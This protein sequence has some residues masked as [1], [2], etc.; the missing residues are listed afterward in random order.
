M[1]ILAGALTAHARL[2]IWEIGG[3]SAKEIF[4]RDSPVLEAESRLDPRQKTDRDIS[5]L[6]ASRSFVF[7]SKAV[8]GTGSLVI[9]SRFETPSVD[10]EIEQ[11]RQA[12]RDWESCPSSRETG[13]ATPP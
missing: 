7:N 3:P 1:S 8:L 13:Y 10:F 4:C 5:C 9:V 6:F 12:G 11:H 2:L